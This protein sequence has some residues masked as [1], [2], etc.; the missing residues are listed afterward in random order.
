MKREREENTTLYNFDGSDYLTDG[1]EMKTYRKL[2]LF[3]FSFRFSCS[4]F[5]FILILLKCC[6]NE[7]CGERR[8]D[9][10]V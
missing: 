1:H 3:L 7:H 9:G 6:L 5:H 2:L 10:L 8:E 4:L